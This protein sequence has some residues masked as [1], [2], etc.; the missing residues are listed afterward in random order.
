MKKIITLI[1]IVAMLT[2]T[3]TSCFDQES[4]TLTL[5]AEPNHDKVAEYIA[6]GSID[7][8]ILPE[9][10]ATVAINTAKTNGF[11]YSIKLNLSEEWDA[12]SDT[13]LTM[14]C[15]V[16][17]NEIKENY[18]KSLADFM[19][20]YKQSIEFIGNPDN[21]TEAAQMITNASVLPKLPIANSALSNLYGSIVYQDGAEMK[22]NLEGFYDAIELQKPDDNFYL[23]PSGEAIGEC[24]NKIKIAVLNGPTGMGMAKL[25]NDSEKQDKYEFKL[26]SDPSLAAT[27]L[28]NGEVDLACLPTNNAALLYN[29][30]KSISVV[31]INCLG[32]L[33]VL[34]KDEI[35]ISSIQDLKDKTIYYGVPASTTAPIFEYIISNNGLELGSDE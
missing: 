19:I 4:S 24:E 2:L 16:V 31:S 33:Y 13:E 10:K 11:N 26:Y 3:L 34:A 27:D 29:K 1:V 12:I 21:K 9:P 30:S 28:L 25:M 6:S 14:G 23:M 32:S 7:V 5:K 35:S 22:N 17:N 8:A 15:I 20:D 18:G